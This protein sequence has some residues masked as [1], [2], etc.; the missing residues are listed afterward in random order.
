[1]G[2]VYLIYNYCNNKKW[3]FFFILV[4]VVVVAKLINR[5]EGNTKEDMEFVVSEIN[6]LN[7]MRDAA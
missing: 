4:A 2:I 6:K 7:R 5:N 3:T 1:M